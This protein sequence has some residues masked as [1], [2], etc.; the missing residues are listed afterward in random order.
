[1]PT[2]QG[3]PTKEG[4]I[5]NQ[6]VSREPLQQ[7]LFL[8]ARPFST[9]GTFHSQ[10]LLRA[11]IFTVVSQTIISPTAAL[12]L[13]LAAEFGWASQV[14]SSFP[15]KKDNLKLWRKKI[16]P[17]S[18]LCWAQ[19]RPRTAWMALPCGCSLPVQTPASLASQWKAAEYHRGNGLIWTCSPS[20]AV[21]VVSHAGQHHRDEPGPF[22]PE[23]KQDCPPPEGVH[24]HNI[25][26]HLST[27]LGTFIFKRSL[28]STLKTTP[29]RIN[30]GQSPAAQQGKR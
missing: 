7:F 12:T 27:A 23:A 4:L 13:C 21:P 30:A 24:P 20:P 3:P 6:P 2:A 15:K 22:S 10:A 9:T 29:K 16:L 25:H 14:L 17:P 1:M 28:S 8:F 26:H 5:N 19:P 18:T 11:H